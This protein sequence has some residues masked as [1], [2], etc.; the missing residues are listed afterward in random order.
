MF[1]P[2][3]Q[4]WVGFDPHAHTYIELHGDIYLKPGQKVAYYD[5]THKKDLV[6][7]VVQVALDPDKTRITLQVDKKGTKRTYEME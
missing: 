4:A 1:P 2:L 7:I 6:G 5:L 3:A